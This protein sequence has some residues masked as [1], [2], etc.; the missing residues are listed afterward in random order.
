MIMDST[1]AGNDFGWRC[2]LNLLEILDEI[3]RHAQEH[4]EWLE[5]SGL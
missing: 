2:N 1:D 4:P 5:L 3:S